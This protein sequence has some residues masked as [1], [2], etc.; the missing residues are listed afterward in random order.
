MNMVNLI[1]TKQ[2]SAC[3]LKKNKYLHNLPASITIGNAQ[4]PLKQSAKNI[5]AL[6]ETVILP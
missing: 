4:I 3:H 5:L 2:N 6:H 1:T